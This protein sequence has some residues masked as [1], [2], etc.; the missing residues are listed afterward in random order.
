MN[1]S[2]SR[3]RSPLSVQ[4][5]GTVEQLWLDALESNPFFFDSHPQIGFNNLKLPV[6][7][8]FG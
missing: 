4:R 8:F 7:D 3:D 5:Q 2:S 1:A 6:V